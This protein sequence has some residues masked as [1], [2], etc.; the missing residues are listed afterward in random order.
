MMRVRGE[1]I[2]RERLSKWSV[3]LALISFV[4]AIG[5]VTGALTV[6]LSILGL[7]LGRKYPERFGGLWRLRAALFLAAIALVCSFF[8]IDAFFRYK[9]RQAE[10]ARAE[11]TMM[12]L[13]EVTEILENYGSKYGEYPSGANTEEIIKALERQ[14]I[15]FFPA[16][17][18]WER[19][20][21]MYSQLWNYS[22]TAQE[23]PTDNTKSFPVLKA[24]SPKPVFPFVGIYPGAVLEPEQPK[25]AAGGPAAPGPEKAP[26]KSA[27]PL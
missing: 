27:P 15:K 7:Y 9:F 10:E 26:T 8:E 12:R 2:Q 23:P 25:T 18:G 1:E 6:F 22:V 5:I 13:Y 17:D 21:I 14:N 20:L 4:P 11:L 19:P 16:T 3:R 24:Q